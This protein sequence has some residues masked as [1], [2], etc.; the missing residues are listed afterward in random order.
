[1][2]KKR[3]AVDDRQRAQ[4]ERFESMI[5]DRI[6]VFLRGACLQINGIILARNI[7]DVKIE[8]KPMA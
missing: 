3:V 5:L 1:M 7:L 8:K 6:S 2:R 4:E